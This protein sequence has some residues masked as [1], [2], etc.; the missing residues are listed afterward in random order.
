MVTQFHLLKSEKNIFEMEIQKKNQYYVTLQSLRFI[1]I[2]HNSGV[3]FKKKIKQLE[4]L[5]ILDTNALC[6][7]NAEF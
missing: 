7:H 6:E 4:I 1:K 2:R 5:K 3:C